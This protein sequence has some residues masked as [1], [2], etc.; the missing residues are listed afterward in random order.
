MPVPTGDELAK[1]EKTVQDVFG[2][3]LKA[4]KTPKQKAE[5][6]QK[7]LETA[8]GSRP[9]EKYAL[10]VQA[11]ELAVAAGDSAVGVRALDALVGR[12]A[13]E[14]PRDPAS[15]AS[16][17]HRLWNQ[18]SDKRP[19]EKLRGR[20][21]AAE[22]Y[23]R[24]LP[25]LEGFQRG[26]AEKRLKDLGWSGYP[27]DFDFNESAEGWG[28]ENHIVGLKAERG[29][30]KGHIGGGDPFIVRTGLRVEANRCPVVRIR[31]SMTAGKVAQFHWTTEKSP[32]W[33]GDKRIGFS[34]YGDGQFHV[35][36]LE[37]AKRENWAGHTITAIRLDPGEWDHRS[38]QSA[39]FAIDY[40][41]GR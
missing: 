13:P 18:A 1:A 36:H 4:A 2:D 7:M 11:R 39:D 41:R 40:V 34:I 27:I 29:C 16:E 15:W 33:D 24:A 35:Y 31:M 26:A 25:G 22:C 21:E 5:L 14:K 38:V 20:L 17:A 10:L 6:A 32:R 28:R 12:F 23:L 19:P 30:L 3:G 9:A 8:A 37:T